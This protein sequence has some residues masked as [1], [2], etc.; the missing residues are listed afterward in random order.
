MFSI[1][2]AYSRTETKNFD[3]FLYSISNAASCQLFKSNHSPIQAD[4][5]ELGKSK[6]Q[7][8]DHDFWSYNWQEA[9]SQSV[10]Q[11]VRQAVRQSGR[12]VGSQ[13]GSQTVR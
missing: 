12:H 4:N 5:T 1:I 9:G 6:L 8:S 13:A 2:Q 10:S 11:A 3:W 7:V